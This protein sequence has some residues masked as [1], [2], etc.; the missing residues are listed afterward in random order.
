MNRSKQELSFHFGFRKKAQSITI[1]EDLVPGSEVVQVQARGLNLLYEIIS[2]RPSPF[3]SI[4]QGEGRS[5]A[6]TRDVCNWE[7]ERH[8]CESFLKDWIGSPNLRGRGRNGRDE[9]VESGTELGR[10]SFVS[11]T[12]STLSADGVVR[13]TAPL[14]LVRVQGAVVTKLQ[15]KAFERLQPWAS[16]VSDLTVIVRAVNQRP[17]RCHPALLV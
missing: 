3:Y 8:R 1:A 4:G 12:F 5:G 16:A 9:L 17:P 10:D 2:P 7:R 15:V 13:T 11:Y 14:D 6:G